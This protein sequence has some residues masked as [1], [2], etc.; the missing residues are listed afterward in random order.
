MPR[1]DPDDIRIALPLDESPSHSEK[2]VG[3]SRIRLNLAAATLG[4]LS[5]FIGGMKFQEYM[6]NGH[7]RRIANEM[8]DKAGLA[9]TD[10]VRKVIAEHLADGCQVDGI[11]G[12]S[13]YLSPKTSCRPFHLS[14]EKIRTVA[15]SDEIEQRLTVDSRAAIDHYEMKNYSEFALNIPIAEV[16]SELGDLF[17]SELMQKDL[18]GPFMESLTKY[19]ENPSPTNYDRL[20]KRMRTMYTD[21]HF[22]RSFMDYRGQY[23]LFSM[24]WDSVKQ[25]DPS[26]KR[27]N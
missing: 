14:P 17:A 6:D 4:I 21:R 5:A 19:Q 18:I 20:R 16:Q 12:R 22:F 13:V 25:M 7:A 26:A 24:L 11:H 1:T 9:E 2:I 23:P 15:L 27:D 10:R 3:N 8:A